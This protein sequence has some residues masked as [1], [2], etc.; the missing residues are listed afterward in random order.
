MIKNALGGFKLKRTKKGGT[1]KDYATVEEMLKTWIEGQNVSNITGKLV[2]Q[3][4]SQ[5]ALE[6]GLRHFTRPSSKWVMRVMKKY[7][8]PLREEDKDF[9][10]EECGKRFVYKILPP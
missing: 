2:R 3:K 5:I 8:I 9:V 10:C 1:G 4:S 7:N 6:N